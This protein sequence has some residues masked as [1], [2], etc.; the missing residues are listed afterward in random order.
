MSDA[1]TTYHAKRDARQA[2]RTNARRNARLA[3]H[4]GDATA[5]IA[6]LL[7]IGA[8]VALVPTVFAVDS[9]ALVVTDEAGEAWVMDYDLSYDDCRNAR[10][11]YALGVAYCEAAKG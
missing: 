4:L 5:L 9:Y 8:L 3:A 7:L 10:A 6:L 11:M 2:K 1:F